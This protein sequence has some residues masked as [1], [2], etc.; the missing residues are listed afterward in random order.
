MDISCQGIYSTDQQHQQQQ[1]EQQLPT[2]YEPQIPTTSYEQ[3][4]SLPNIPQ[5]HHPVAAAPPY[6]D[7]SLSHYSTSRLAYILIRNETFKTFFLFFKK[8]L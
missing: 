1:Q 5:A 6:Y 7:S 2:L 8:T 3:H 4:S